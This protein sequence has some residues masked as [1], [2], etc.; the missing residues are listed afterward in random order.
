LNKNKFRSFKMKKIVLSA[1]A[2]FAMSSFAVAGGDIAPVDVPVVDVPVVDADAGFYVGLAYGLMN[3]TFDAT[4]GVATTVPSGA[5]VTAEH[6]TLGLIA[7]YKFNSYVAVEGRYNMSLSAG[8]WEDNAVE[9]AEDTDDKVAAMGI[10]VKPMYPVTNELDVYALLGYASTTYTAGT[11]VGG[12]ALVAAEQEIVA[13]G[14]AYGV[15][16]AYDVTDSVAVFVDYVS[17]YA[18]DA[19]EYNAVE[20]TRDVT[21]TSINAGVTYKF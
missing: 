10:Y 8:T 11:V 6:Q 13:A 20:L 7:G 21:I 9:L 17:L 4:T 19:V 1:V 2:V 14:F 16:I 5:E 15:G 12:N 18:A 3:G